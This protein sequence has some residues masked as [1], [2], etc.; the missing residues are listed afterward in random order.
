MTIN[1]PSHL[2]STAISRDAQYFLIASTKIRWLS[3]IV[4]P[5]N[6]LLHRDR[7]WQVYYALTRAGSK[8]LRTICG[9]RPTCICAVC[10]RASKA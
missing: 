8:S 4:N 10:L 1:Q 9:N 3:D 7:F 2:T 6:L 5:G